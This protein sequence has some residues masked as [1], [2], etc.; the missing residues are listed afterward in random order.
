MLKRLTFFIFVFSFL[1]LS[2]LPVSVAQGK[3]TLQEPPAVTKL[4]EDFV[5]FGKTNENVKAWRI[6]IITTD[7]RREME[8]ARSQFISLYP[9]VNVDWKHIVPYYQVRVGAYD[10]KTKLMPFL[11]ELKKIFPAATPVYD[12]ISK[13]TLVLK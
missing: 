8:A 6:Q 10:N 9:Y 7:D 4:M 1:F 12:Q 13:R 3:I 5:Q 11:L 2:G